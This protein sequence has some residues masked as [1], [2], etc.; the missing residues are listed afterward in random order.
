MKIRF[1]LSSLVVLFMSAS[2]VRALNDDQLLMNSYLEYSVVKH[3]PVEAETIAEPLDADAQAEINEI[4]DGWSKTY[5]SDVKEGLSER[6]GEQARGTFE[7]FVA[8]L[9]KMEQAQNSSYLQYLC[10]A[11]EYGDCPDT[12]Q[13]LRSR[14]ADEQLSDLL[15]ACGSL[16]GEI[17]T[18]A[19]LRSRGVDDLPPLAFWLTRSAKMKGVPSLDIAV[20]S[21]EPVDPLRAVEEPLPEY[22]E[23]EEDEGSFLDDFSAM[24]DKKRQQSIDEAKAAMEQVAAERRA[25]E[26]DIAAKKLAAAQKEAEAM[27]AHAKELAAVEAQALKQ[28]ERTF[29]ARVKRI[30]GATMTAAGGAFIGEVGARAGQE[31]A[32]ALFE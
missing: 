14:I 22:S 20:A 1:F 17:Q 32:D 31:A 7:A 15:G 28:R 5:W 11:Y 24:E 4:V 21:A 6:F 23:D 16:L 26:E 10:R 18:W 29:G 19:D 3:I 13:E 30:I 12:Y 8:N 9:T 2:V 25:V 27:K